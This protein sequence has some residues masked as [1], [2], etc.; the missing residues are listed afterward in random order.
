MS[1][2]SSPRSRKRRSPCQ[3]F[4]S[5]NN[6]STQT[7]RLRRAFWSAGVAW[8][9]LG[10]LGYRTREPAELDVKGDAPTLPRELV[11]IHRKELGYR[12]DELR[13]IL[14]LHEHEFRTPYLRGNSRLR[15]I[16]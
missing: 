8:M 14:G 1:T 3:S 10:R 13:T 2:W 5:P 12:A 9:Q 4:A 7:G 11:D 15:V 6:G 16:G